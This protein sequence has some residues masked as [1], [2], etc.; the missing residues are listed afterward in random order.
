MEQL[1]PSLYNHY[2]TFI[3][4]SFILDI[5][6]KVYILLVAFISQ[7][8]L[9]WLSSEIHHLCLKTQTA[10]LQWNRQTQQSIWKWQTQLSI[11]KISPKR[12]QSYISF[13]MTSYIT[14]YCSEKPSAYFSETIIVF[15]WL[16][17]VISLFRKHNDHAVFHPRF[18][19]FGLNFQNT[20]FLGK[21]HIWHGVALIGDGSRLCFVKIDGVLAKKSTKILPESRV[22]L[23]FW[24]TQLSPKVTWYPHSVNGR[25]LCFC[26]DEMSQ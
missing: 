20:I 14:I 4:H 25:C 6:S 12:S 23:L 10:S 7:F 5:R 1:L 9:I 11:S 26:N 22:C 17:W 18:C 8:I 13:E 3:Y 19:A 21:R 24:Q 15:V 16:L 2:T